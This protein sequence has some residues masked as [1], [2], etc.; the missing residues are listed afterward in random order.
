MEPA[1][2]VAE[3][4]KNSSRLATV[5]VGLTLRFMLLPPLVF[6]VMS[7]LSADVDGEI[8]EEMVF[9]GAAIL[10]KSVYMKDLMCERRRLSQL[11]LSIE[12]TSGLRCL[13]QMRSMG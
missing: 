6:T 1:G 13:S 3:A 5:C 7:M 9:T 12:V 8:S 11:C 2:S 10:K 4:D